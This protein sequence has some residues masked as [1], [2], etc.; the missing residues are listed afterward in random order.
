[1]I[2]GCTAISIRRPFQVREELMTTGRVL[3]G[4]GSL[5]GPIAIAL[6]RFLSI[7][8]YPRFPILRSLCILLLLVLVWPVVY[9]CDGKVGALSSRCTGH[10]GLIAKQLFAESRVGNHSHCLCRKGN[11]SRISARLYAVARAT[12]GRLSQRVCRTEDLARSVD[13]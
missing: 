6:S 9:A 10:G 4:T 3:P 8:E 7:S 5:A 1:M 2:R 12:E 13:P 11:R